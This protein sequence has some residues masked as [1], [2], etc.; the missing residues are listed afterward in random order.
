[1]PKLSFFG[2]CLFKSINHQNQHTESWREGNKEQTILVERDR[3]ILIL[4]PAN[5]ILV[6]KFC[7]KPIIY[8][9]ME[10]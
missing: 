5:M 6:H 7:H 8:I 9:M 10:T 4:Q 2:I 1:M 3:S